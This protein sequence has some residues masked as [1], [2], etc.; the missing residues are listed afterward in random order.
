MNSTLH[1]DREIA[2]IDTKVLEIILN[3]NN[4]KNPVHTVDTGLQ[5]NLLQ[6]GKHMTY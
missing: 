2:D 5:L 1:H 6:K 4:I 3:Y